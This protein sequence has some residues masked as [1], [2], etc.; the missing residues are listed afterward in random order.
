MYFDIHLNNLMIKY[1]IFRS[2]LT[3]LWWSIQWFSILPLVRLVVHKLPTAKKIRYIELFDILNILTMPKSSEADIAKI[4]DEI[5]NMQ[6]NFRVHLHMNYI[7]N[8]PTSCSVENRFSMLNK[9]LQSDRNF[10]PENV[11]KYLGLHYNSVN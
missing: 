11:H 6:R 5:D 9:L 3:I 4:R 1:N 2:K 7:V 8:W 10:L